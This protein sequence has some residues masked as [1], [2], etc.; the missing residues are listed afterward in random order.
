MADAG[1]PQ[2]G[3]AVGQ[4]NQREACGQTLERRQAVLIEH[5]IIAGAE[6]GVEGW[7]DQRIGF[8]RQPERVS[9]RELALGG[10]V[11]RQFR[12]R[13]R[14]LL[15]HVAHG[16]NRELRGGGR[17]VYQQEFVQGGFGTLDDWPDRP[18]GVVEVE[19]EGFDGEHGI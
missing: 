9:Q 1:A 14:N 13:L 4:R 17:R 11:V 2:V 5:H 18:E 6:E 15:A 10:E 16:R 12:M 3:V 8:A 7:L 19:A